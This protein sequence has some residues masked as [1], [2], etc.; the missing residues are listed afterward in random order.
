[1]KILIAT[2]TYYPDVNGASYSAQRLA[3]YL[4]ERGHDVLVLASSRKTSNE[5]F[6]HEGVSICGVASLPI[7]RIRVPIP[8]FA[9]RTVRKTIENFKPDIIQSETHFVLG[10]AAIKI[11]KEFGIPIVAT[12]HFMPENL[13]HYL[14]LP[15]V[16]ERKLNKILWNDFKKTFMNADIITSPTETAARLVR[17]SGIKHPVLVVSNGVDSKIFHPSNDGTFLKKKYHIP[18][19]SVLLF[20][21]RLDKEKNIDSIIRALAPV[22]QKIPTH[23]VIVGSGAEQDRLKKLTRDLDLE[24]D[25]TFT[26]F[27]PDHE[28]PQ[29]YELADCFVIDG[30]AELQSMVTMEAMATG[31]PVIAV[32]AVALPELVHHGENGLLFKHGNIQELS[33]HILKIMSDADLRKSMSEQSLAI[34]KHHEMHAVIDRF[35]SLYLSILKK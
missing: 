7:E 35:E 13:L 27:V 16:L 28:L 10:H 3:R 30:T 20:V 9:S 12:N 32:D 8:I 18:D 5:V 1:M 25:V 26:G 34:I 2:A 6:D 33:S 15:E 29:I 14:H 19:K 23:F 22:V 31:L 24:S 17:S 11:G 21:G 4:K